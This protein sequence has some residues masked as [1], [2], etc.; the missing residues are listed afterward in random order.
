V[1]R[2]TTTRDR[3]RTVIART[4][5]DCALCFQPIDY[6]LR[7]PDPL[8]FVVDH[9]VPLGPSPTP[10]RVAELDVLT[11]KQAAHNTCNRAKW[12]KVEAETGPR[13]FVTTRSW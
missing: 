1:G 12:D 8:C 6:T 3:H 7:Y 10:E 2:N 9:I 11:N 4:K 13:I 5:P